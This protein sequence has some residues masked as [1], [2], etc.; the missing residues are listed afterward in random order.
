MQQPER[1]RWL[2]R[3]IGVYIVRDARWF[4][5]PLRRNPKDGVVLWRTKVPIRLARWVLSVLLAV[6]RARRIQTTY[7]RCRSFAAVTTRDASDSEVG[8]KRCDVRYINLRQRHDRR[9]QF[10]GEMQRLGVSWHEREEAVWDENGALGCALSHINVLAGWR[11]DDKEILL[12]CEDDLEFI[13]TRS[14]ID[15]VIEEFVQDAGLSI[16]LLAHNATWQVPISQAVGISSDAQTTAAYIVRASA[17][18]DV[19][20]SFQQ[21]AAMLARG[22][23]PGDAAIDIVWK[24]LQRKRVFGLAIPRLAVQRKD[25]SDIEKIVTDYDV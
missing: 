18:A 24:R 7:F 11:S 16:L 8:L 5:S 10:E 25:Y 23:Q 13:G 9:E 4:R 17:A 14:D 22:S 15:A 3:V 6:V 1:Y 20:A 12:V 2:Y 19:I 21:S